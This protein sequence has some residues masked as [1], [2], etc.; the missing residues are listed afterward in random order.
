M[1]RL[2]HRDPA[3]GSRHIVGS[4]GSLNNFHE[5]RLMDVE[6]HGCSSAWLHYACEHACSYLWF[7][8]KGNPP[9]AWQTDLIYPTRTISLTGMPVNRLNVTYLLR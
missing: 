6:Q 4:H 7:E 5:P 3:Y 1:Y 2:A 9:Q 8:V